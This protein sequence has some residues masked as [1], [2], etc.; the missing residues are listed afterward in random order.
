[1]AEFPEGTFLAAIPFREV[2][3]L[4]SQTLANFPPQPFHPPIGDLE[5]DRE[6]YVW[7]KDSPRQWSVFSPEGRWLGA[8][9]LPVEV[10]PGWIEK[11]LLIGGRWGE[12]GVSIIE[13][14]RLRRQ[15]K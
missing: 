3:E 9:K 14:F 4:W 8:V 1:M 6:G 2:E 10:N 15:V 7:V 11:D 13:G 12:Y 5:V